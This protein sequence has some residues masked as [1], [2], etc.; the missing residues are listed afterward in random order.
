MI[1]TVPNITVFLW[2]KIFVAFCLLMLS[3]TTHASSSSTESQKTISMCIEHWP[4]FMIV[5][6]GIEITQGSWVTLLKDIFND[7]PG[8]SVKFMDIPW[9]RCLLQIKN[10]YVDGTLGHFKTS[11]R[12][13][14][15]DYTDYVIS[16]RSLVWYS[17]KNNF[18]GFSWK[19][20]QDLKHHT[21][22]LVRGEKFNDELDQLLLDG[23]LTIDLAGSDQQNFK[24]L[25]F[26]RVDIIIKNEKVGMAIIKELSI[27][28]DVKSAKKPAYENFRYISFSKVKKHGKIIDQINIRIKEMKSKGEIRKFLGYS[29][30]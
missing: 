20:Y 14:Y 21:M 8:Y 3:L 22:G 6:P 29:S 19:R 7:I 12:E 11:D 23:K 15:M 4:P 25:A 9:K 28:N 10:G 30:N 16:D 1:F 26:G 18:N 5:E 13:S 27:S 2:L 24:K 17:T